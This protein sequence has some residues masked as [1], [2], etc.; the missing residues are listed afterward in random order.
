MFQVS[1]S[2]SGQIKQIL[3]T[4]QAQGKNLVLFFQG[5]G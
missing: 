2:A 3:A 1:D 4:E 5:F